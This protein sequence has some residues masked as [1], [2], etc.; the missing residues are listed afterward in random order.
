MITVDIVK[1]NNVFSKIIELL[2]QNNLNEFNIK[3]DFYK[4]I[5]TDEWTNF[6]DDASYAIGSLK[7]DWSS[8][9]SNLESED[10]SCID[11]ERVANVLKAISGE[12]F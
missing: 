2:E 5:T 8:L 1:L 4:T 11:L 9:I 7:D 12:L 6:E 10:L 3:T